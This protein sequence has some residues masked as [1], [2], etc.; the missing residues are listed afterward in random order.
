MREEWV[1]NVAHKAKSCIARREIIKKDDRLVGCRW[2][3]LG[4]KYI[5]D[6]ILKLRPARAEHKTSTFF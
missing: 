6:I 1:G 3:T 2:Q 4:V 5:N